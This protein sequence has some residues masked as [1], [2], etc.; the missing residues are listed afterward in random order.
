M[1]T[2]ADRSLPT[3]AIV[4][5]VLAV[6]ALVGQLT[7]IGERLLPES[8]NTM[9]NSSGPWAM[10]VFASI[11]FSRLTGWRAALLA[12]AAFVVMDGCFYVVFDVLGGL[13]PH[14]YLTFWVIVA[15]CVGPLVGLCASWLR[16]ANPILRVVA[17][18]SPAAILVGEG[19]FMLTWLPGVSTVYSIAS[20]V[21]G[22]ALFAV[23]AVAL[24]RRPHRV[25]MSFALAV[26]ATAAFVGIYSLLPLV[27][28]KVVP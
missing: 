21:V 23:L 15:I 11:Y 25:A 8:I 18:A 9:A 24:L 6:A 14:H 16:S 7:P 1:R 4:V 22:V 2:S 12:L 20:V 17:V 3:G 19:I 10:V 5:I 27:L 28:D 13:Y 26:V